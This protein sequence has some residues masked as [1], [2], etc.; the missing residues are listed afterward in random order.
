MK[1]LFKMKIVKKTCERCATAW[2]S[3]P[4]PLMS[5]SQMFKWA[6]RNWTLKTRIIISDG[7]GAAAF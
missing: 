3:Y 7:P 4:T 1:R 5:L 2:Q 6:S